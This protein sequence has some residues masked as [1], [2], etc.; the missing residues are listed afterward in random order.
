MM[1]RLARS[2][3]PDQTLRRFAIAV[4][5]KALIAGIAGRRTSCGSVFNI[6]DLLCGQ[7]RKTRARLAGAPTA[8]FSHGPNQQRGGYS[9]GH[10]FSR[11]DLARA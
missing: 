2:R 9:A 1:T 8:Q 7:P 11:G 3:R 10:Q 4:D 6:A 5:A